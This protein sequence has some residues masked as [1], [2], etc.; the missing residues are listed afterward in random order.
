MTTP[1][2]VFDQLSAGVAE[3]RFGD[4]SSLY[5]EDTVCHHPVA[6]P[7]PQLTE[8]RAGVHALFVGDELEGLV[9]NRHDV[10]IHETLDPE[11]IVAEFKYSAESTRTGITNTTDNIQMLRVHD[12]LIAYSRDYHDYLKIAVLRGITQHL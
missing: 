12:G 3:G 1:R 5:A 2:E 8:G 7:R 4:L 10:V 9:M 6:I 11:V